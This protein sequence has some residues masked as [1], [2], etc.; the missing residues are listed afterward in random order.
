MNEYLYILAVVIGILIVILFR[1][2]DIK[3][4]IRMHKEIKR[5]EKEIHPQ[6]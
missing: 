5:I 2:K 1:W 3:E 4:I 6:A